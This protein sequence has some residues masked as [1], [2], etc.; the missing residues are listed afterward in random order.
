[1][2]DPYEKCPTCS[3]PAPHL[4][5]AVQFE[6]EVQLCRDPFHKRITVE[7]SP[8]QVAK[9]QTLIEKYYQAAARQAG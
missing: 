5:P 6:G 7:N 1:M 3:S 8:A 2:T 9:I 4:H